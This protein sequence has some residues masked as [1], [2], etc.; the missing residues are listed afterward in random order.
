MDSSF[1][2]GQDSGFQSGFVAL[3]GP[4]NAGKSTLLNRIL[5]RTVAIVTPKPQTTRN[6]ILG[7]YH[8]QNVQIVLMD[9]PGIHRTRT[10]L[11]RSM[12][13]SAQE[14]FQEVDLVVVLIELRRPDD[15]DISLLLRPLRQARKSAILVINKIDTGPRESLLPLMDAFQKQ[16]PFE[17][18]VPVSALRGDGVDVLLDELKTRMK[19]GPPFFPEDMVTDQPETFLAAELIREQ[20]YREAQQELPYSVA[21]TVDGL[22]VRGRGGTLYIPG[23]IHVESESQKKIL[24]GRNGRMIKAIGKK[25]R[26]SLESRFQRSVYLDLTVRVEKNWSRNARALRKLGYGPE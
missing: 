25:A 7:I 22:E 21:V 23:Q 26:K 11:H 6:R 15:P 10:A 19:P 24:V 9:T 2:A 12:V 16:Y 5:G 1:S 20:V 18:I 3:V 14:A 4:P 13:A 17:A 8:G